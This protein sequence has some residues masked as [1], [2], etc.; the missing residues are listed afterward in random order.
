[1]Q[2]SS[3]SRSALVKELDFP[4]GI[5]LCN[6][7]RLRWRVRYPKKSPTRNYLL[8]SC[9]TKWKR[10]QWRHGMRKQTYVDIVAKKKMVDNYNRQVF[11]S[12]LLILR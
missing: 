5:N 9:P 6:D 1:M 4:Q 2:R 11:E 8:S 10:R 7:L 3:Q 12:N